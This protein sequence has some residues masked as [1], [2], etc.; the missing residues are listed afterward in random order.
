MPNN[1]AYVILIGKPAHELEGRV[2]DCL[3]GVPQVLC[4]DTYSQG[5]KT[6]G[7]HY[8]DVE[9]V[10]ISET[11]A[12]SDELHDLAMSIHPGDLHVIA[13]LDDGIEQE[14]RPI[15]DMNVSFVSSQL[16]ADEII[17]ILDN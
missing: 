9:L 17:R 3:D 13:D 1:K 14:R 12:N 10:M 15:G 8:P 7:D 16:S 6:A 2:S 4:V 11:A 5:L